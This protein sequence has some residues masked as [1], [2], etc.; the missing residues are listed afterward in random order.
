MIKFLNGVEM[1]VSIF[2]TWEIDDRAAVTVIAQAITCG[3]RHIDTAAYY[4]N[5][6]GIGKA[7]KHAGVSREDIFVTSKVWNNCR[8]YKKATAACNASLKRLGLDYLDMLL[9]HWPA[10]PEQTQKWSELNA[11]TWRA[12][13]D[14]Q[15]AGKVKVIGVSNFMPKHLEELKKTARILP[16]VNQIE[17]HPGYMQGECVKYCKENNIVMEAWSPLG[18]GE[19]LSHPVICDM[20]D[21]YRVTP[22]ALVLQW[23][24][25]H[26]LLPIVKSSNADRMIANLKTMDPIADADMKVI[27]DLPF[28]GR[29]G[30][31]PEQFR[32]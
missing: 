4:G 14:L 9:I 6:R 1:P 20:A 11:E 28:W 27:D 8:G 17:F 25:Q 3:Y 24:R 29:L 2:G 13:E 32:G 16:M 19:A 15:S 23:V 12:L 10:V 21:R 7:I 18:R 31:S 30:K 5:E 22:A 26:G